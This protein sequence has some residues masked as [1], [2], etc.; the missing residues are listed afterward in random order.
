MSFAAGTRNT[1]TGPATW[2]CTEIGEIMTR[3]VAMAFHL[4]NGPGRYKQSIADVAEK[5]GRSTR[6]IERHL[7]RARRW[8]LM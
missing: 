6:T 7:A 4:V 1:D 2:A 3:D 5:M 8:G